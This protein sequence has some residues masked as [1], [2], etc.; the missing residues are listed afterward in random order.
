MNVGDRILEVELGREVAVG[1]TVETAGRIF[2]TLRARLGRWIGVDAFDA[3][4]DRAITEGRSVHA[5][6]ARARWIPDGN[7]PLSGLDL[8]DTPEATASL[9]AAVV[10]I[11][12]KITALLG[13]FIGDDL[14][15]RL[16]M[17]DW[18]A[19]GTGPQEDP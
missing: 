17:Q 9:R 5:V 19:P 8:P 11:L 12:D 1:T 16:V 3:L 14:A 18:E 10:A 15:S 7:P 2:L 4:M 6:L 13:R